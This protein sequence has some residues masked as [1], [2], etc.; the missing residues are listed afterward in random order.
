[1]PP[2]GFW[3]AGISVEVDNVTIDG[4]GHSFSESEEYFN[5]NLISAYSHI[6]LG[7]GTFSGSLYGSGEAYFSDQPP[8]DVPP[9]FGF[10]PVK[11]VVVRNIKLGLS[12]HFG[13]RGA[14]IEGAGVTNVVIEKCRFK[15]QQITNI[16]YQSP[17]GLIIRKCKFYGYN[18]ST[19]ITAATT[20]LTLATNILNAFVALGIPGAQQQLD[21]LTLFAE[22][23]PQRFNQVQKNSSTNYGI[24]IS[25]GTTSIFP[26]P[27]TYFTSFIGAGASSGV[28]SQNITIEKC[29]FKDFIIT[30]RELVGVASNCVFPSPQGCQAQISPFGI[31]QST[32]PL[33]FYGMNS[34][35]EWQDVFWNSQSF[36]PNAFIKSLA[37]IVNI[38][39][40][41]NNV[42]PPNSQAMLDSILNN[43]EELFYNNCAPFLG[44]GSDGNLSKGLFGIRIVSANNV[45][46]KGIK[47]TNFVSDG[48][49]GLVPESLPGYDKVVSPL[50]VVRYRGNDV[51]FTSFEAC[52]DVEA[53][54]NYYVNF[55]K[56]CLRNMLSVNGYCFGVD[57]PSDCQNI[58]VKDVYVK[59]LSA[60]FPG[61][62]TN[63]TDFGDVFA[64]NVENNNP[65]GNIILQDVTTKNLTG[66][67]TI[68]SFPTPTD[69]I[70]L[71]NARAL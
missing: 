2:N 14:N 22:E 34:V 46:I 17:D 31:P 42:V 30:S 29:C 38:F 53:S 3:F 36:N 20:Q 10:I 23:N 5:A 67:G 37:F 70:I 19:D 49:Q 62:E 52:P 12:S 63:T 51:W 32:I 21:A 58:L 71:I 11:N 47:M 41:N 28:M 65:N 24:F 56:A 13:I 9:G 26:F 57:M 25:S 33:T 69:N 44:L 8:T 59:N 60:P 54:N 15:Q 61:P 1:M 45:N 16:S 55:S 48:P 18:K 27:M 40:V 39:G 66:T 35:M 68:S 4:C 64:F 50:P 7:N 6:L 43:D